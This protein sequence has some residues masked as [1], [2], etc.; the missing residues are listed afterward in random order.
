MTLEYLLLFTAIL[1]AFVI[2]T[3]KVN[4]PFQA[5]Y[6]FALKERAV[7][8]ESVSAVLDNS[9]ATT[10]LLNCGNGSIDLGEQCDGSDLNGQTCN[11]QGFAGGGLLRCKVSCGFDTTACVK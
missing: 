9:V 10:F 3:L 2:A 5:Q 11:S 8:M 7:S 6:T 4:N 1:V